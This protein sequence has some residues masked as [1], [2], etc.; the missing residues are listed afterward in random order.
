MAGRLLPLVRRALD[1]CWSEC[2]RAALLCKWTSNKVRQDVFWVFTRKKERI[3]FSCLLGISSG[4]VTVYACIV[5]ATA[6]I[7]HCYRCCGGCGAAAVSHSFHISVL[8]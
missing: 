2:A 8:M 7:T 5:N 4:S 1:L 3:H 6:T